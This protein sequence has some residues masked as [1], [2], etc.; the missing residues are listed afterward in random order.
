[1]EWYGTFSGHLPTMEF[2]VRDLDLSLWLPDFWFWLKKTWDLL[3]EVTFGEK[4]YNKITEID[5]NGKL[6]SEPNLIAEEFNNFF[7]KV[8]TS[9]VDAVKCTEKKPESYIENYSENLRK[10]SLGNTGPIH[11]SDIIK[12]FDNKASPDLDGISL[13]LIKF[14]A[15]EISVP[16]SHIFNLSLDSGIFPEKLK[17]S[18]TVPIFK[19]GDPKYCDNYRPISLVNTL[20]K[21]LEKIVALNL[22][23]HLQI[24]KLLYQHQYGFQR[25]MSTEHN[26]LHVVNFISNALNKGNYCIGIFL[27]LKK[28]F[29]TCSHSILLKKLEKFGVEGTALAWF[30][31][32]LKN[33]KQ[34]VDIAGN[35]SDESIFNIS[36]LQGSILGPT[37]FLCYIN[38]IFKATKL[39]T[40]LFADD[41]SC[42]AEHSNLKELINFVNIELQ[43][44]ACWFKSNKMAVNIS[45]TKY[46]IFRNK[47]KIIDTNCPPVVFN[48]KIQLK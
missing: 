14:I 15:I 44:L 12:S 43:K 21:I 32:Y 37:L 45:K 9:I 41:T 5:S 19:Q 11:V 13:K 36:V 42:L 47:G 16:L 3:K 22:V 33:R 18:R 38:D 35:F 48:S 34:K 10:F 8:G 46:I 39:A 1:M 40:F 7:S 25:A 17:Y 23:N 24:N 26:L 31:S 6:L 30:A 28:A 4:S 20:S 2:R 29:D 27:D